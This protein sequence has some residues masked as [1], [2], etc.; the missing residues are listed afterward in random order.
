MRFAPVLILLIILLPTTMALKPVWAERNNG[1]LVVTTFDNLKYD[2]KQLLAPGDRVV[3]LVPPGVDPHSYSLRP[4]DIELLEKA[5]LIVSTGHVAFEKQ[6][7]KMVKEG[8]IKAELIEIP[9]IP[10]I[11]VLDNPV[12]GEPN[13]HMPIYD[14]YNYIVFISRL[15]HIMA[16]LRPSMKNVYIEREIQVINKVAEIISGTRRITGIGVGEAPPVQYAVEWTGLKIKY[17]AMIQPGVPAPPLLLK[18]INEQAEQHKIDYVVVIENSTNPAHKLLINLAEKYGLK[19]IVVPSPT[20]PSSILDKLEYIVREIN[21][22]VTLNSPV[23]QTS[24]HSEQPLTTQAT[25]L[26]GLCTGFA[27]AFYVLKR[28]KK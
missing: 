6:I 10:G 15:A 8:I 17:L 18:Q 14:P 11:K 22:T 28:E 20:S 5:D 19:T 3:S 21:S 16:S 27:T 24:G 9:D 4:Q 12:T 13:L 1:L 23:S 7:E 2:I 25:L 26:L